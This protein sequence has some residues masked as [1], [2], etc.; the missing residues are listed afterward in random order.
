MRDDRTVLDPLAAVTD[1]SSPDEETRRCAVISVAAGPIALVREHLFQAMGDCSWRV[2]KEA[3]EGFLASAGASEYAGEVFE[4]LRSQDN[5]GLRSSAVEALLRLGRASIP[6]LRGRV[7]DPD[8]DVRK[9]VVDILGDIGDESSLPSLIDA[10]GDDDPNVMVAAAENLGKVGSGAAVEP[11]LSALHRPDLTLRFTILEALGRIGQPL[12]ME[13]VS[14]FMEDPLLKK[15]VY[16]CLGSVGAIES[17]PVLVHGLGEPSRGCRE[18]AVRGLMAVRERLSSNR[19]ADTVDSHLA[20]L[21]GTTVVKS[22]PGLLDSPDILLHRLVIRLLGLIGDAASAG[23]VLHACGNEQ[24]LPDCLQALCSM[25]AGTEALLNEEFFRAEEGER[26]TILC[27]C[28]ELGLAGCRSIIGSGMTDTVPRVREAAVRAAGRIGLMELAPDMALMLNDFDQDVRAAALQSMELLA[29]TGDASIGREALLLSQQPEPEKRRYAAVLF[30]VLRDSARLV[31]LMKDADDLVRKAAVQGSAG[32]ADDDAVHHL[33]LALTD[34]NPAVRIA[35]AE[36][37][38]ES[39]RGDVLEP[40]LLVARDPDPWVRSAGLKSL[41]KIGGRPVLAEL[42]NALKTE[43]GVVTLAALDALGRL[44]SEQSIA[45]IRETLKSSDCDVAA[46]ALRILA[47][48]DDPWLDEQG[49]LLFTHPHWGIRSAFAGIL[50]KRHG[51]N[52]VPSLERALQTESDDLV[53]ARI[54]EILDTL[55]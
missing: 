12:P 33:T 3:V 9:F 22:L 31:L 53:K 4:L 44:D 37:L 5:A 26:Y 49:D 27:L 20:G 17:V 42:E 19:V 16:E 43:S 15:A 11:L 46:F 50:A 8:P 29:T 35:A 25:G 1:L 28:G 39:K 2:R 6:L 32:L 30:G 40:L 54:A 52:A 41:G 47:E 51:R 48:Q 7:H 55:R 23:P 13:A 14:P 10:L 21:K 18:A 24:L 36:A 45:L 34:E 38:G